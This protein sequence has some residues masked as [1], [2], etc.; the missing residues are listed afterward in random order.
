M[1]I[2]CES[3]SSTLGSCELIGGRLAFLL[4]LSHTGCRGPVSDSAPPLTNTPQHIHPFMSS[5]ALTQ[6]R[7]APAWTPAGRI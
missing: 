2:G 3:G 6:A 7:G 1:T 5:R 4:R